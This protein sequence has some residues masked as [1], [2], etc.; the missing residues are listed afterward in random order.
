MFPTLNVDLIYNQPNQ[1]LASLKRDLE[2]FRASGANQISCYPLMASKSA[3]RRTQDIAGLPDRRELRRFYHAILE[4]LGSEFSPSSA[5]CFTRRGHCSDEYIVD[6][7]FY[8]G[9]G[10]GAFSY[11]NGTLYATTFSLDT[12]EQRIAHGLTGITAC[13]RL[14]VADQLRYSLLVKMFGL[15]LDRNW[16]LQHHGAKFFRRLWG[17]LRSLEWLGAARRTGVGWTLTRRGM[18]WLMLMMSAFFEAVGDYREAMRVH[19]NSESVSDAAPAT[20][21]IDLQPNPQEFSS[22]ASLC[23]RPISPDSN[24]RSTTLPG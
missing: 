4:G 17:E 24:W 22:S 7:D 5:W 3:D 10:S 20:V 18:Y 2:L 9:V 15:K 11:L 1:T 16:A 6:A 14:S 21:S 19:I 13:N 12:Y 23:G 8:V